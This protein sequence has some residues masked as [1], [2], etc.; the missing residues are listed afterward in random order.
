MRRK[1]PRRRR[2]ARSGFR[3]D[4]L[5]LRVVLVLRLCPQFVFVEDRRSVTVI[6]SIDEYNQ[7]IL[8]GI[9]CWRV[10]ICWEEEVENINGPGGG[11]GEDVAISSRGK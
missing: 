6:I 5:V 3:S 7:L 9:N 1:P 2:L 11:G 8:E 4:L 10:I